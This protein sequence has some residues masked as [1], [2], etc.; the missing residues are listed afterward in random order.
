MSSHQPSREERRVLKSVGE[1]RERLSDDI[2]EE[3]RSV[4][5]DRQ[6]RYGPPADHWNRTAQLWTALLRDRLTAPLTRDDVAR[7]Y[8]LDKLSRDSNEPH[9]DAIVDIIGYAVGLNTVRRGP[10]P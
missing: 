4:I 10:E 1:V 3:A 5:H 2:L 6:A 8:I 7:L 9:H